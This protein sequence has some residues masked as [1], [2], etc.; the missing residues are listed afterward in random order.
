MNLFKTINFNHEAKEYEVRILYDKSN[1]KIAAFSDNYPANGFRY[2]IIIPKN[3]DVN[4]LLDLDHFKNFVDLAK[5]D[6]I[7][8][9]W[10]P[11]SAKFVN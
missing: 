2:Q 6:I 8:N 9:R 4:N 5:N 10:E 3:V 7:E 11:F 1:I